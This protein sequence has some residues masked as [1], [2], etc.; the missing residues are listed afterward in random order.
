MVL[1]T[2]IV[3]LVVFVALYWAYCL[4]WGFKGAITSR[5]AHDYFLAGRQLSPW[6]FAL[7]VTATSLSGWVFLNHPGLIYRDGFSYGFVSLLAVTIPL[8]GLLFFKRQWI[9]GKRF[10]FVTP[11]EMFAYYFR[12]DGMRILIAIVAIIISIPFLA[13]CLRTSGTLIQV[14]TDGFVPLDW[15]IWA[16]AAVFFAY[17]A[18][19]GFRAVAHVGALQCILLAAGIITLGLAALQ[20]V[21][22]WDLFSANTGYLAETDGKLTSDGYSHHVAIPGVI[23]LVPDALSAEGGAW[24]GA[25][26]LT[27]MLAVMGIQSSPAFSMFAFSSR[28]PQAF[29]P[30]Q[31]WVSALGVGLILLVF[32]TI[33]GIGGHFMGANLHFA[34]THPDKISIDAA[35]ELQANVFRADHR[36]AIAPLEIDDERF[37]GMAE[38]GLSYLSEKGNVPTVA[39]LAG[40]GD[41]TAKELMRHE[42]SLGD[43]PALIDLQNREGAETIVVLELIGLLTE[44]APWLVGLLSVCA[45]AALQSAAAGYLSTTAAMLSRD[46]VKHFILPRASAETEKTIARIAMAVLLLL[47]LSV[48]TAELDVLLA[49]GS[50]AIAYGFQM[51]PA[52]IAVCFWPYLTRQGVILGLIAGLIT[53]TL[54]EQIGHDW[55]G[56][57]GWGRWPLTIHAAGWGIVVNFAIATAVSALVHEHRL[58]LERK[59]AM[60]NVLREHAALPFV[61]QALLPLAWMVTLG[62]FFFAVGPGAVIGNWI[63]GNP[64][65]A[66]TWFFGIPSIWAWQILFW[67]LGVLMMWFLAYVMQLSTGPE[68]EIEVLAD[69]IAELQPPLQG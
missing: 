18:A 19:G 5:T 69:D 10:G 52:L 66:A 28:S 3:W 1:E 50:L 11:G 32:S 53:V 55:F 64:T 45:L 8:T 57:T 13:F 29:A 68:T 43:V 42:A 23:Q 39:R 9:L 17:I 16:L 38:Q 47:A 20:A 15:G 24:T 33:Q 58:D 44:A 35:A 48:A 59:Y 31:V 46:V 62:W 40:D 6:V 67:V 30:Q 63:F 27:A 51:W 12:S 25:L 36:D 61:R 41:E 34:K 2:K 37:R 56:I 26:I 14:V 49:L 7:A 65:N 4:F 21:G 22:G 60:H 54:T